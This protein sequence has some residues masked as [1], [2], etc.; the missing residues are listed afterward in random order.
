MCGEGGEKP[1]VL[2]SMLHGPLH[3]A[4]YSYFGH[5]GQCP[6][7]IIWPKIFH[8]QNNIRFFLNQW[9]SNPN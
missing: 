7:Q 8:Y 6:F 2:K 9:L 3:L 1:D 4:L 5:L